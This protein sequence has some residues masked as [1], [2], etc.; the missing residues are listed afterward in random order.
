MN[1]VKR[2]GTGI[3]I[4]VYR[5]RLSTILLGFLGWLLVLLSSVSLCGLPLLMDIA[6]RYNSLV[7][8]DYRSYYFVIA[9]TLLVFLYFA[10]RRHYL[11]IYEN[12][13]VLSTPLKRI[14]SSWDNVQSLE[15][16]KSPKGIPT[17]YYLLTK[18][19]VDE[20][21][22]TG[23]N[24][25]SL[26]NYSRVSVSNITKADYKIMPTGQLGTDLRHFAPHLFE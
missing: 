9:M 26:E 4:R 6:D 19:D 8:D 18:D 24:K 7:S 21:V 5:P 10:Y 3:P 20:T 23:Q 16:A 2:D 13:I 22:K 11:A 25:I 14:F 1:K 17:H 12:G 15:V